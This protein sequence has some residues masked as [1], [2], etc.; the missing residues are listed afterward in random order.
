MG[1]ENKK[2]CLIRELVRYLRTG[3][4]MGFIRNRSQCVFALKSPLD[5]TQLLDSITDHIMRSILNGFL[6]LFFSFIYFYTIAKEVKVNPHC[7]VT[8]SL[9]V[10]GA[11]ALID[12]G[13]SIEQLA[14]QGG[15]SPCSIQVMLKYAQRNGKGIDV[16]TQMFNLDAYMDDEEIWK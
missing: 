14:N 3:V 16:V 12:Q 10:G 8:H 4:K 6:F 9:R 2:I 5:N 13:C 1:E 15:W 7:L 11:T